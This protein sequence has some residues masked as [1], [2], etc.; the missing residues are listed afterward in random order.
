MFAKLGYQH[1]PEHFQLTDGKEFEQGITESK[2]SDQSWNH[3][4][5]L[6]SVLKDVFRSIFYLLP[7]RKLHHTSN[8]CKNMVNLSR[9]IEPLIVYL[10]IKR[11]Q[12]FLIGISIRK[13]IQK[14][15]TCKLGSESFRWSDS[16]VCIA[17]K[18]ENCSIDEKQWRLLFAGKSLK[19][20]L[21]NSF[22]K[23]K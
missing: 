21:R 13:C 23:N 20:R 14:Q 16:K 12:V 4:A 11:P 15:M 9:Q 10:V 2:F 7:Q 3:S 5:E 8:N 18:R 1:S 19:E 6:P 17:L 22:S